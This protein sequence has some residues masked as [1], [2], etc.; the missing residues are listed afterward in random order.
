MK[1]I[2]KVLFLFF[3]FLSLVKNAPPPSPEKMYEIVKDVPKLVIPSSNLFKRLDASNPSMEIQNSTL[4][5]NFYD[6]YR[7]EEHRLIIV[8]KNLPKSLII[9]VGVLL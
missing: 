1:K 8:S 7:L 9:K 3:Y 6:D 2:K 4:V 5:T